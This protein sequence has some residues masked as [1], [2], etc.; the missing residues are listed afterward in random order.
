MITM[1]SI[2][3]IQLILGKVAHHHWFYIPEKALIPNMETSEGVNQIP[4]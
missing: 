4:Y 1:N 3:T 2:I